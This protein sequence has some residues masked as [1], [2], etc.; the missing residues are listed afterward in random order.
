MTQLVYYHVLFG[1]FAFAIGAAIGSFLNVCIYRMPRGLSINEPDRSFCPS[2]G[3]QIPWQQNIPV[4]SWLYLR[5]K[6]ANCGERI[7]ARYIFVE[8]LVGLLFLA[9]YLRFP[10]PYVLPYWIFISLLVAAAFIDL[11]HYII[12]DELSIGGMAAGMLISFLSPSLMGVASRWQGLALSFLGALTG[13]G[14]LW[15]VVEAG[16]LAFGK[17]RVRLDREESFAISEENNE[18]TLRVGDDRARWSELFARRKDELVIE[19]RALFVNGKKSKPG[20]VRIRFNTITTPDGSYALEEIEKLS[21]NTQEMVIPRE[22]M[23][24][25]D[26][27]LLGCI[28]A[29]LGWAPVFFTVI[30]A[31]VIGALVGIGVLLASRGGWSLRIPFGP[32]LVMGALL[33]LFAGPEMLAWY[34]RLLLV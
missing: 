29:F 15:L 27:K 11:E 2:C 32:Y 13:V 31:S 21:G 26:V 34:L 22:A 12:P 8:V 7:A 5:G 33:W 3:Y 28:G 30:M 4:L 1:F 6:C 18:P 14:L 20:T 9:V 19:A 25:G 10:L 23:G 16:K 17:K 24:F